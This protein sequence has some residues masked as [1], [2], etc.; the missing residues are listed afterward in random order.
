MGVRDH[1]AVLDVESLDFVKVSV[2]GAVVGE[3]PRHDSYDVVAIN[4]HAWAVEGLVT[5]AVGV[6]IAPIGVGVASIR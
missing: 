4:G 5:L 1:D 6:E 2:S 3:E